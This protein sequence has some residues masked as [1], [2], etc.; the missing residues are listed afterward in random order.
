[1]STHRY[2]NLDG[3]I[4]DLAREFQQRQ[5][6]DAITERDAAEYV[7]AHEAREWVAKEVALQS[8]QGVLIDLIDRLTDAD[9]HAL[10]GHFINQDLPAPLAAVS[11]A[12]YGEVSKYVAYSA[13]KQAAESTSPAELRRL[14]R[15]SIAAHRIGKE[16]HF[17]V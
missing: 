3:A 5:F 8:P 7:G 14:A 2:P 10:L 16:H 12:L 13:E 15:A 1:M 4:S 17:D 9:A 11:D 6:Q